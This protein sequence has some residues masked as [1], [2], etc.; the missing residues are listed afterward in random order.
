MTLQ[1][2]NMNADSSEDTSDSHDVNDSYDVNDTNDTNDYH[3]SCE[4]NILSPDVD[5]HQVPSDPHQQHQVPPHNPFCY[6]KQY[7]NSP[8]PYPPCFPPIPPSGYSQCCSSDQFYLAMTQLSST[9]SAER[10][11]MQ[12]EMDKFCLTL[13]QCVQSANQISATAHTNCPSSDN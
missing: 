10:L 1:N 7:C 9:A 11:S 3:D 5:D 4:S 6:P 8:P 2:T 13:I 12:N